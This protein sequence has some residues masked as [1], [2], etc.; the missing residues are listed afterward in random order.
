MRTVYVNGEYQPETTAK[1]SIFDRGFI[2]ADGVYEVTAVIAG[3]LVDFPGHMARLRRSLFEVELAL[4]HS[5]E[6][7]LEIHRQLIARNALEEG[8]IYLQVSRGAA[9]RDFMYPAEDVPP[10]F[11]MFTQKKALIDNPVADRGQKI[12]L[13]EDQRWHRRDIKTVQL[14]YP[15]LAKNTARRA[16]ADDAWMVED[17]CI[18]EGCSNNAYIVT[19]EGTL[20][21]RELSTEILSGI[22]RQSVLKCADDLQIRVEERPFTVEE[23]RQAREAFSTSASGFVNPVVSVDGTA[24]GDGKPGPVA[25]RLR[26]VYIRASRAMAI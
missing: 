4:P 24:V 13:V 19:Q 11:V 22:T 3:K 10:T 5:D 6:E 25:H 23:I 18:T 17:G 16:G 15:V 20:V 9:D 21:T 2:F 12:I 8:L 7:V 26:E 1:I 14:L